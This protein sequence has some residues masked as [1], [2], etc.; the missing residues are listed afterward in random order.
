MFRHATT[1]I[2]AAAAATMIAAGSSQASPAHLLSISAK[3]TQVHSAVKKI[4]SYNGRGHEKLHQVLKPHYY[5]ILI[6]RDIRAAAGNPNMPVYDNRSGG[7]P[8]RCT[9]TNTR[10]NRALTCD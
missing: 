9:F 10:G 7:G 2:V 5:R 1:T 3:D 4:H 6:T 8:Y